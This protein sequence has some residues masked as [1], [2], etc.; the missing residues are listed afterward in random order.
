MF[1]KN[2]IYPYVIFFIC[3]L[4]ILF[5]LNFFY[6]EYISNLNIDTR[7]KV[8][9][10]QVYDFKKKSIKNSLDVVIGKMNNRYLIEKMDI[11]RGSVTFKNNK[12]KINFVLIIRDNHQVNAKNIELELNKF[13]LTSVNKIINEIEKNLY[14][15]N[16]NEFEKE[17]ELQS[18]DRLINSKFF[19][20]YPIERCNF[21]KLYC[22]KK[23]ISYYDFI[24]DMISKNIEVKEVLES[25]KSRT[26]SKKNNVEIL[27]DLNNNQVLFKDQKI[28]KERN[29]FFLKKLEELKK[30]DFFNEFLFEVGCSEN[31]I[32]NCFIE[33]NKR[34]ELILKQHKFESSNPFTVKLKK[35]NSTK[36]E[37]Y[38]LNDG[39]LILGLTTIITYIF[40]I[41]TNKF[42]RR[43]LK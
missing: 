5:T 19:R 20:E 34:I 38:I 16:I 25:F 1:R 4:I 17:F 22:Y 32:K 11:Q 3:L 26:S 39:P 28:R 6:K 35:N 40:F 21:D 23:Y 31:T 27:E 36:T 41:L 33:A 30:T 8:S 15:I 14:L 18:Y 29:N 42:F 43:K 10:L 24:F 9:A 37:N 13:Y 7:Y 2:I 12:S